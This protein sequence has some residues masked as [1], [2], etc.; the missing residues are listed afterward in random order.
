MC[1]TQRKNYLNYLDYETI[2][3]YYFL[4]LVSFAKKFVKLF[5]LWIKLFTEKLLLRIENQLNFW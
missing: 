2:S 5:L 4:N 3:Q 1:N